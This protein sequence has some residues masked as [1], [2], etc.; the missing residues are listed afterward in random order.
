MVNRGAV[1]QGEKV[2]EELRKSGVSHVVWLP[3]SKT[4]FWYKPLHEESGLTLVPVCREG[5]AMAVSAGLILGGKKPVTLIQSPGFF[6]SGDSI[7]GI[8]LDSKLPLL[9]M[10]LYRGFQRDAPMKDS[11]GIYL[12]PVLKAFGIPYYMIEKDSDLP[13][14]SQAYRESQE[15]SRTIAVLISP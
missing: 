7:R 4:N 6:E 12:E 2:V 3:D 1:E 9:M 14:I 11:A 13:L 5:E 15:T 8:C 10:I